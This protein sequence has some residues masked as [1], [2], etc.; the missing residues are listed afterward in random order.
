MAGTTLFLDTPQWQGL[1]AVCDRFKP[2]LFA[3]LGLTPAQRTA[4]AQSQQVYLTLMEEVKKFDELVMNAPADGVSLRLRGHEYQRMGDTIVKFKEI[5]ANTDSFVA[6]G[7]QFPSLYLNVTNV[8]RT[9][10][11]KWGVVNRWLATGR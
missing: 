6:K 5:I 7:I 10:V 3:Y 4:A 9:A 2:F 11:E 8:A 1:R